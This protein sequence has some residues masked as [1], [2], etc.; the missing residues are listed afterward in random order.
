RIQNLRP[1]GAAAMA[2]AY[3]RYADLQRQQQQQ[4]QQ[5]QHM[6]PPSAG[7]PQSSL[8]AARQQPLK[9]PRP[10]DYSADGPGAP[11][12]AG[13]YPRDEERPGYAVVR[14]TQALNASY[15]R[16]LRTGVYII[17]FPDY[18]FSKQHS[19]LTFFLSSANPVLWR[20][21]CW[22]IYQAYRGSQCWW[23]PS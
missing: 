4:Q 8:A 3:W 20:W 16:F 15:E 19:Q 7:A 13:Y 6:P 2:D 11:E 14:D 23:L 12:M 17:L 21:T 5:Q 10:G 1:A 9:R 18:S 22:W